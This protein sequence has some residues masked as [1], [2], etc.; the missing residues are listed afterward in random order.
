M[1]RHAKLPHVTCPACGGRAFARSSGKSSATFREV[2]Y[3]CRNPD[4]CGHRFVVEMQ[5]VRT[6]RASSYPNP[7]HTLP[8]TQWR[9]AANDRADN[10]NGPVPDPETSAAST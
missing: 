3:D 7:L 9:P 8:M 10:D 5:A 1:S 4:V 2:Y 6:V